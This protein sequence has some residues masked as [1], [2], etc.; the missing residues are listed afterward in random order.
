MEQIRHVKNTNKLR[1]TW[2]T[3]DKFPL[4]L[5]VHA[6]FKKKKEKNKPKKYFLYALF[7][8]GDF[9]ALLPAFLIILFPVTLPITFSLGIS[10]NFTTKLLTVKD[11]FSF[12]LLCRVY[13]IFSPLDV[14][15]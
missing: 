12:T 6:F 14:S 9:H 4:L 2:Q 10:F 3:D 1:I 13:N 7:D 8:S 5:A 11:V 15:A